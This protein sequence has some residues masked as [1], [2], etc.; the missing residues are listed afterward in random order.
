MSNTPPVALT[1]AGSDSG[2]GAGIQADIKAM[3]ALGVFATSAITAITAQNTRGVSAVHAVPPAV[4]KAQIV[5]V[6]TDFDVRAIKTGM[7]FSA[8]II[9]AVAEALGESRA[10]LVLDPVMIAT[11]G[12]RLIEDDAVSAMRALLFPRAALITPNLAE[13]AFLCGAAIAQTEAEMLAQARSIIKSGARAVLIKG[14]H[15]EGAESVDLL[16]SAREASRFAAPRIATRN[17]HG[18]GCTLSAAIAAYLAQGMVLEAA[19]SAAKL[20][21]TEAVLAAKDQ[22]LGQGAGPVQHFHAFWNR[23]NAP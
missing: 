17:T 11:S 20:Y 6:L 2:G 21:L 16:V 8:P 9:A 1:I 4:V 7:L 23:K 18:T 3:S 19:V 13:A 12:D 15:G 22:R 5:A 10:P 14:G